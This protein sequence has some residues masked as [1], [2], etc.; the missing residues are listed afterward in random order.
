VSS[1]LLG[2]GR[3]SGDFES[4]IESTVEW[5]IWVRRNDRP[6]V[7]TWAYKVGSVVTQQTRKGVEVKQSKATKEIPVQ[8]N[9]AFLQSLMCGDVETA[10]ALLSKAKKRGDV[11]RDGRAFA[12]HG[13]LKQRSTHDQRQA[14]IRQME[15]GCWRAANASTALLAWRGYHNP[16]E[17]FPAKLPATWSLPN[18]VCKSP[19]SCRRPL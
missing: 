13:G 9:N 14:S 4:A 10:D 8:A 11:K 7:P 2:V 6:T 5:Q 3:S 12:N 1:L 16:E 17:G 19:S 15:P 18:R